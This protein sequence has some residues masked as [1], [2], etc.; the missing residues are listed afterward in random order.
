[1]NQSVL[2]SLGGL[3]ITALIAGLAMWLAHWPWLQ[4]L[5]FSPLMLSIIVG[6]IYGNSFY[7]RLPVS[8]GSGIRFAQQKL[9][10]LGIILFG[11]QI[12]FQQIFAVGLYGLLIDL[13]IVASVFGLGVSLGTRWLKLDQQTSIL[14]FVWETREN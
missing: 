9:L 13:F 1:M 11:L 4:A 5:S 10:R 14:T 12:T 8:W 6:M 2:P 7:H 3:T